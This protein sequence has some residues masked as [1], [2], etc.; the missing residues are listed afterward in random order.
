MACLHSGG[1]AG[2]EKKKAHLLW[3]IVIR[4]NKIS[5]TQISLYTSIVKV[6]QQI[7]KIN[8]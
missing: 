5:S 2:D 7:R 4:L 8:I 1:R 6:G 3:D